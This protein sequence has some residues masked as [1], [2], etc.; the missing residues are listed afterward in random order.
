MA[1][2]CFGFDSG[3]DLGL[4]LGLCLLGN[5]QMQVHGLMAVP[6]CA[7]RLRTACQRLISGVGFGFGIL[8]VHFAFP[9]AAF[10]LVAKLFVCRSVVAGNCA[11]HLRTAP[12]PLIDL[13][14]SSVYSDEFVGCVLEQIWHGVGLGLF[15]AC[16]LQCKPHDR[17]K[18]SA[19]TMSN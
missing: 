1:G 3:L 5:E 10:G 18:P 8:G 13:Q 17:Q 19:N 2:L 11:Q 7:Q 9:L 15:N 14:Y 6:S 12:S 16:S 4:G